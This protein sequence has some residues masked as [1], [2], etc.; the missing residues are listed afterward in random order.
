MRAIVAIAIARLPLSRTPQYDALEYLLWAQRIA[1]GDFTWPA[2]PPHGPAYPYFLGFLLSVSGGS[3]IFVRVVQAV[4]GAATCWIAG[5]LAAQKFGVRAGAITAA[6][7]AIYAPLIWLDA[8][9]AAEGLLMVLLAASLWA[10]LTNK[11]PI[12][13][14]VLVGLAALTRPTALIFL[15]LLMWCA[16][17]ATPVL[18]VAILVILPVTI[19][20]WRTSHAL[21][22]IQAFGGMNIYLGDSPLRDGK[23]SARPGAEWE[24]IEPEAARAGAMSVAAEDRYF[25]RKTMSEIDAHPGAFARLIF[26]KAFWT[27]QNDEVRDTHSFYFF[28]AQSAVLRWLPGFALLFGFGVAGMVAA[29]WKDRSIQAIGA[30]SALA[31]LTCTLLV[32]GARYRVPLALGLALFGGQIEKRRRVVAAV[33]AGIVAALFSLALRDRSTHNFSEE[34]SLTA[35]SLIKEDNIVEADV[36]AARAAALDPASALAWDKMGTVRALENRPAEAAEGFRRAVALNPDYATAHEH[37]GLLLAKTDDLPGAES[38]CKRAVEIDPRNAR[39]LATLARLEGALGRAAQGLAYAQRAAALQ[40]PDDDGWIL[41]AM[42]A[43][44][45]RQ[46]EV[47]EQ[48]LANVRDPSRAEAVRS[49]IRK[50]RE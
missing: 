27:M 4:A 14:G 30:Y 13:V 6:L 49:A 43:A 50:A 8:S 16:R 35:A 40:P 5:E 36:A 25:V 41:I 38:E 20:N 29:D 10:A 46:F 47:A 2:N 19:A 1:A 12:L 37:L 31:V 45:A 9:I 3:L 22:P 32:V 17:R 7:L 42:L 11:A 26:R 24:R 34:W 48:A 33:V 23:A 15:P 28:A 39:A 18:A 44:D 21:M